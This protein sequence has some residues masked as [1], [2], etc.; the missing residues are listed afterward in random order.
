MSIEQSISAYLS[1]WNQTD[2]AR[3]RAAIDALFT[4][5][6]RYADPIADVSGRAALDALIAGVQAQF[7]GFQFTLAGRV[8]AHHA[9][10]RFTWHAAPAQ[11]TDPVVIGFDVVLFSGPRIES[12]YGFLDKVPG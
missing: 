4:E 7:A 10:A 11:A 8:D 2:P 12:V 3:R 1:I 6:C 5:N 9:Q